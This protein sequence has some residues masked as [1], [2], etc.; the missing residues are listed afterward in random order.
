MRVLVSHRLR[1]RLQR[2]CFRRRRYRLLFDRFLI[3]FCLRRSSAGGFGGVIRVIARM[4]AVAG[5][6]V[7]RRG[8]SKDVPALHLNIRYSMRS[9]RI[10][11]SKG[12]R[13]LIGF[14]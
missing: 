7:T 3:A 5:L 10:L 11:A 8:V 2:S 9:H 13:G 12:P 1:S 4:I 14:Y 6:K